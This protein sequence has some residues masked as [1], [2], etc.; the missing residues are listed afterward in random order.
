MTDT[1]IRITRLR[2]ALAT[3]CDMVTNTMLDS[4]P[5]PSGGFI[6]SSEYLDRVDEIYDQ[7]IAYDNAAFE[8]AP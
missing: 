2:H 8:G 1:E 5:S 7:A 4:E 3:V 6:I